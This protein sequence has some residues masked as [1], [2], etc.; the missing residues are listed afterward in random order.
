MTTELIQLQSCNAFQKIGQDLNADWAIREN[1][2]GDVLQTLPGYIKDQDIFLIL[3]FA[4]KYEL[5]AFNEGIKFQKDKQNLVLSD[6]ILHQDN[7]IKEILAENER[8][9]GI[10]EQHIKR[11]GAR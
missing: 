11:N 2:T 9:A 1:I 6:K 4:K 8:L 5:I 7:T 10:L 3:D